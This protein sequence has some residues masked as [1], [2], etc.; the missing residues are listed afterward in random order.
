MIARNR[1]NCLELRADSF[2]SALEHAQLNSGR[3]ST[4]GSPRSAA[5]TAFIP[6]T[7]ENGAEAAWLGCDASFYEPP[8][9]G[10]GYGKADLDVATFMALG[11]RFLRKMIGWSDP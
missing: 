3:P 7:R 10:P 8:L 11:L 6:D 5:T 1:V 4:S 2:Q 9:G